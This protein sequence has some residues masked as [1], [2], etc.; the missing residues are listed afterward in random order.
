[1]RRIEVLFTP[2]EFSAL[3]PGRLSGT[4]CVVFD[5]LRATSTMLEALSQGALG[6]RPAG[7]IEE[8]LELRRL[9]PQSLLAGE[10]EGLR[11]RAAQANGTDF[12]LGNSPREFTAKA[13]GGR[14]VIMTTTNGTRALKACRGA[15]EVL[16]ASF[17]NIGAVAG[18]LLRQVPGELLLV[19]GGTLENASFEDALGAGA[20][21]DRIGSQYGELSVGSPDDSATMAASLYRHHRAGLLESA[22]LSRNGRRLLSHPDLAA[23]IPLCLTLD[24]L[25]LVARLEADG[26]IRATSPG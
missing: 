15:R 4:T 8:A 20:L 22:A 26:V 2:I 23:D 24:R 11:I 10:R 19:C 7:S 9:H 14:E 16:I 1:M 18:H 5:V 13:V 6:I 21:A 3:S 17:A 12:D 25:D